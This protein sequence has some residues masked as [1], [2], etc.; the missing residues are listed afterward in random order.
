MTK[1]EIQIGDVL[2]FTTQVGIISHGYLY[3]L[4]LG[5]TE[6]NINLKHYYLNDVPYYEMKTSLFYLRF[7][8]SYTLS[9]REE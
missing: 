4:V 3:S 7:Y 9:F 1:D 6:E 5:F 8:K 2:K